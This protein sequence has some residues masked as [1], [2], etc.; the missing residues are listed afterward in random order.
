MHPDSAKRKSASQ[1][2]DTQGRNELQQGVGKSNL[3]ELESCPTP[4]ESTKTGR[5][6]GIEKTGRKRRLRVEKTAL[7]KVIRGKGKSILFRK[8]WKQQRPRGKKHRQVLNEAF[9][10]PDLCASSLP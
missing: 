1:E 7:M 3:L 5:P 4:N 6:E 8:K 9:Y 2:E 10:K